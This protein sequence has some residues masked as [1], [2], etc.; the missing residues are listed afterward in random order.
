MSNLLLLALF[1]ATVLINLIDSVTTRI[2]L[3]K[4]YQERIWTTKKLIEELGLDK[5]MVVKSL[6]PTI[7]VILV[8]VGWD[9]AGGSLWASITFIMLVVF[10]SCVVAN[11]CIQLSKNP[12]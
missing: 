2:A 8:I 6:L 9:N 5:A 10:F 7:L 12:H 11:N 1:I 4:G 3:R